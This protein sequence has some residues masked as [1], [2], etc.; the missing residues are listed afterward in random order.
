MFKRYRPS[1]LLTAALITSTNVYCQIPQEMHELCGKPDFVPV[2]SNVMAKKNNLIVRTHEPEAVV[3]ISV[4][5]KVEQVCPIASDRYL[6]FVLTSVG[7]YEIVIVNSMSGALIDR[8]YS[9]GPVV[10]PDQHWLALRGFYPRMSES[11]SEE[12][13]LYDLTKNAAENTVPKP[14]WSTEGVRGRVIYPAVADGRPFHHIGL[15]EEQTHYIW[16][17][18]FYWSS[19]S[20][21]FVFAD[22]IQDTLSIVLAT[23]DTGGWKTSIHPLAPDE[24]K[25]LEYFREM[26]VNPESQS[27]HMR[28]NDGTGERK[29][30]ALRW[31]DFVPAK[32]EVHPEIVPIFETII[33]P[34]LPKLN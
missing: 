34:A 21:A 1:I 32:L 30:L 17:D 29:L 4:N 6:V 24:V 8:F 18:S 25:N 10:S 7:A 11:P 27:I 3:E 31:A 16:S 5:G 15:P 28:F 2:P 12:Y 13:L 26:E 23:L 19:D 33:V 20:T 22:K 9:W 14:S